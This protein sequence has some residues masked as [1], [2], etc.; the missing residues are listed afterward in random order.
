MRWRNEKATNIL[1]DVIL[2]MLRSMACPP[3]PYTETKDI[4]MENGK[5]DICDYK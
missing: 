4:K 5:A 3:S 1:S 2:P